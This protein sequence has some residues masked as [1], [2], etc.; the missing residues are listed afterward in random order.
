M[1]D[2]TSSR[3]EFLGRSL[4]AG[5]IASSTLGAAPQ[6]E[7]GAA[8]LGWSLALQTSTFRN[9]PFLDMVDLCAETGVR[10]LEGWP[11]QPVSQDYE[12]LRLDLTLPKV[13][14]L[15]QKKLETYRFLFSAYGPATIPAEEEP[16]RRFLD[17]CK[18]VG[19]LMILIETAPTDLHDKLCQEMGLYVAIHNSTDAWT[20][21]KVMEACKGRSRW[22]GACADTGPW[23]RRGLDAVENL[24]KLKG[25]ILHVHPK[26]FDDAKKEV[27]WGQGKSNLKGQLAE[28]KAQGFKGIVSIEI[29]DPAGRKPEEMIRACVQFFNRTC[30]EI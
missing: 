28:L 19:A 20:P 12:D 22:I 10:F 15:V 6:G 9:L 3:R 24:R 26:D 16:A 25:R 11:G 7:R 2:R 23:S 21:E 27:P 18:A 1:T 14:Q 30:D 29:D 17:A 5:L 13:R 8:K 4:G